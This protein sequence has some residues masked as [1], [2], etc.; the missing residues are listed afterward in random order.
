MKMKVIFYLLLAAV[1][2]G[3][4]VICSDLKKRQKAV[5]VQYCRDSGLILSHMSHP[6]AT[7]LSQLHKDLDPGALQ[8]AVG[9]F[10]HDGEVDDNTVKVFVPVIR[11]GSTPT[12]HQVA[13]IEQ[14]ERANVW[15]CVIDCLCCCRSARN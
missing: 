4:F 13:P 15:R 14:P 11:G 6:V 2:F 7:D 5:V 1:S 8:E 12:V 10:L 3:H 9:F